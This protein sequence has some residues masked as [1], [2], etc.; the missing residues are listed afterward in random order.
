MSQFCTEK[1]GWLAEIFSS[2]KQTSITNEALLQNGRHYWIG[3]TDSSV[4]GHFI[5]QHSSKPLSWSNWSSGEP[6][7][8]RG[9]EDCVVLDGW[10]GHWNDS[11]CSKT[12]DWG[13]DLHALCEY[14]HN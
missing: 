11:T 9:D 2:E 4:E 14:G 1:G 7:N 6:N 10:N 3:L 8:E 13:K 12:H 5:W